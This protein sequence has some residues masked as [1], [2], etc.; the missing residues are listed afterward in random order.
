MHQLGLGQSPRMGVGDQDGLAEQGLWPSSRGWGLRCRGWGS[1]TRVIL[2]L[3]CQGRVFLR[4]WWHH[5]IYE[6]FH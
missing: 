3:D 4:G 6:S 2:E 1:H 5:P